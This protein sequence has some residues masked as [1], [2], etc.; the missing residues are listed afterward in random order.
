MTQEYEGG[1]DGSSSSSPLSLGERLQKLDLIRD[2]PYPKWPKAL[3]TAYPT[4]P[5]WVIRGHLRF[6][7]AISEASQDGNKASEE[8]ERIMRRL[9]TIGE[10]GFIVMLGGAAIG[11]ISGF[12]ALI[13]NLFRIA[14]LPLEWSLVGI[15]AGLPTVVVGMGCYAWGEIGRQNLSPNFHSRIMKPRYLRR[16]FNDLSSNWR[17]SGEVI[18][19][20][21][22]DD[23]DEQLSEALT[24]EYKNTLLEIMGDLEEKGI[25]GEHEFNFLQATK[26]IRFG[27]QPNNGTTDWVV[28]EA[29]FD[30]VQIH[31]ELG[32]KDPRLRFDINP[33]SLIEV[34]GQEL[35]IDRDE[36]LR[37]GGVSFTNINAYFEHPGFLHQVQCFV[38]SREDLLPL[39]SSR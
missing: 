14:V 12:N 15:L 30:R 18:L 17:L 2:L 23:E 8:R 25:L 16:D 36:E 5:A 22:T 1:S 28:S 7:P 34:N 33:F 31:E 11:G 29:P 13:Y 27:W 37:I 39:S 6:L 35:R 3:E 24:E 38:G 20:Q 9:E 10:R 21:R 19:G 32:V 26:G 4:T